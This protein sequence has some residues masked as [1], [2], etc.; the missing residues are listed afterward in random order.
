M[1]FTVKKKIKWNTSK[2]CT[3]QTNGS[4]YQSYLHLQ[5]L[6]KFSSLRPTAVAESSVDTGS[7]ESRGGG[8]GENAAIVEKLREEKENRKMS[9]DEDKEKSWMQ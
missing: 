9:R 3:I 6:P 7:D 8:R 5:K 1:R 4:F 2:K